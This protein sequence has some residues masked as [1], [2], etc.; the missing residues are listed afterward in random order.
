M[1]S[2]QLQ[3]ARSNQFPLIADSPKSDEDEKVFIS[4]I[5]TISINSYQR[6]TQN[7]TNYFLVGNVHIRHA[8][9]HIWH[10]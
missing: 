6:T 8:L 3:Q 7:L 10:E 4:I 1:Y 2:R 5:E 9:V